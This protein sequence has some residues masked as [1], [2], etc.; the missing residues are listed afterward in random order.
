ML[1]KL[2]IRFT[3]IVFLL[4]TSSLFSQDLRTILIQNITT[5]NNIVELDL[6]EGIE[7]TYFSLAA[8]KNSKGYPEGYNARSGKHYY[9][10]KSLR[11]WEGKVDYVVTDLPKEQV[12]SSRLVA[13][14]FESH[15]DIFMYPNY[16]SLRTVNFSQ[17][18]VLFG[19][20]FS[21]ILLGVFVLVIGA[22][23]LMMK[24]QL[25]Q[26]FMLGALLS[27]IALEGREL[28]ERWTL[29]GN[30]QNS[31]PYVFPQTPV[32]QFIN[33][34]KPIVRDAEWTFRGAFNDEYYKICIRYH[35]VD[36]Y[37][38]PEQVRRIIPPSGTYIISQR[39]L[40]TEKV[41]VEVNGFYLTQIP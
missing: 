39:P 26:C 15:W 19:I 38:Y 5:K 3:P 35:L 31:A 2:F 18:K 37:Y 10:L 36:Q 14:S 20:P 9:E 16:L 23:F 17:K 24:K 29:L 13:P 40:P 6:V 28:V 4:G 11:N 25:A 21:I 7:G 22:A 1:K 32:Q 34:I 8:V 27:V 12:I 33:Q 30:A 41:L